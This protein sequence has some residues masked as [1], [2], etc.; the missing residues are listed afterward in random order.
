MTTLD[1]S[2]FSQ[3]VFRNFTPR[4][5][6]VDRKFPEKFPESYFPTGSQI[7]SRISRNLRLAQAG[8]REAGASAIARFSPGLSFGDR[9]FQ[10]AR[11]AL[12]GPVAV[13]ETRPG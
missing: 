6:P 10:S 1:F 9:P 2:L 8:S 7:S 3:N 12:C 4:E 5:M 13:V 11:G